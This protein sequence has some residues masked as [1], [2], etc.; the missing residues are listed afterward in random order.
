MTSIQPFALWQK[1][2]KAAHSQVKNQEI[3]IL[4]VIYFTQ[5]KEEDFS[6]S[7]KFWDISQINI[8]EDPATTPSCTMMEM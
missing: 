6:W 8:S 1:L 3:Q 4:T 5:E 2:F 7:V